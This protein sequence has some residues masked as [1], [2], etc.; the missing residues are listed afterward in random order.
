MTHNQDSRRRFHANHGAPNAKRAS[1]DTSTTGKNYLWDAQL[2]YYI[3]VINYGLEIAAPTS[4]P[5]PTS[6]SKATPTTPPPT[7][8][9]PTS[10]TPTPTVQK[11]PSSSTTPTTSTTSQSS[12]SSTSSTS[13]SST[14]SSVSSVS[15]PTSSTNSIPTTMTNLFNTGT[16]SVPSH[17]L[18]FVSPT[19]SSPANGTD[20]SPTT[21]AAANH[22][23]ST[24]IIVV[25]AVAAL[26]GTAA[27]VMISNFI[28]SLPQSPRIFQS[29]E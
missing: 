7:S 9:S 1:S 4:T 18:T 16:L 12:Q 24:G 8:A 14:T 5:P 23:L 13:S 20:V 29:N 10:K 3:I 22:G 28:V 15:S 27:V 6:Q 25:I 26:F 11:P 21:N 2:S 19:P 17:S